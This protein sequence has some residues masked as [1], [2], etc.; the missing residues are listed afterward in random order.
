MNKEHPNLDILR[1]LDLSNLEASA[2]LF[3]EDFVW[4]YYNPEMP[5]VQGDYEGLYGLMEFFKILAG[6]TKGSFKVNPINIA[7][8]GDELV[9]THVKDTMVLKDKPMEIDAIVIWCII[10]GL[11]K[12]AWDIPM[13][14][15]AKFQVAETI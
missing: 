13:I 11:I 4:H 8:M 12:E 10:D 2:N 9:I 14:P 6:R 15:T 3:A 1:R 5:K 7:P